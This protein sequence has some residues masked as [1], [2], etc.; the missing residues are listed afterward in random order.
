MD[1]LPFLHMRPMLWVVLAMALSLGTVRAQSFLTVP[2]NL[3]DTGH[4]VIPSIAVGPSGDINVVWLDSGAILFRHSPAGGGAFSSTLT[5]ATTDLPAQGSQPQV[6]VNSA[7]VY[8]AWAGTNSGGG[9]DI[10]FS[11]LASGGSA[12][13]APVNVSNTKG[14]ASGSSAPIPR[15]AVDPSGGV[16]IVWGQSAAY[17]ARTTNSGSSFAVTQ[18]STAPMASESPRTAISTQG[19]VY[20]VWENAGSC[21]TIT[22]GRSTDN[23]ANFTDYAVADQLTVNGAQE[24]GCTSDVQIALGSNN[25]IHLLWANDSPIQDLIATYQTDTGS[26]FAGFSQTNE[27]GFQNLAGTAAHTP[28][29]AID[30]NGNINVVWIGD[31]QQ[32]GGPPVVYFSRSTTGGTKGSFSQSVRLRRLTSTP[33]AGAVATGFPQ[34]A[35][36]PGGAIDVIWQQASATNP[37]NAYDIVLARS[38]DGASFKQFTL[39]NSPTVTANTG[40][41]AVDGNGNAYIAWLGNSGS[42]ADILLNG[43]SQGLTPPPPVFSLSGVTAS[44]SPVSAVINVNGIGNVQ[45][46]GEV[47]EYRGGLLN[48]FV[49]WGAGRSDLRVQSEPAEHIREWHRIRNAER[50]R[51]REAFGSR[52]ERSN[53]PVWLDAEEH[54]H[55]FGADV[56]YQRNDIFCDGDCA[57][58]KCRGATPADFIPLGRPET[59]RGGFRSSAGI[60]SAPRCTGHGTGVL[61]RVNEQRRGQRR[62][63]HG[64][65]GLD[66]FPFDGAGAIEFR[67][68]EPADHLYHRTVGLRHGAVGPTA[69]HQTP[70][71]E[72][73]HVPVPWC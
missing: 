8:V 45:F 6:A 4:A 39:D 9:G 62:G 57:K 50:G 5:V 66:H 40:Q 70:S 63:W 12:F 32:N 73:K 67:D 52:G 16:D 65:R 41:I 24:T 42:S 37:G 64:R 69:A 20:V 43:D 38:T 60:D 35:T 15:I 1:R 13:T 44:I 71:S 19:T 25:T 3:S 10:F 68:R 48:V 47:D 36:E 46:V 22:F 51:F 18:L 56:G 49:R 72:R 27:Q 33:P 11:S 7:G 28:Q 23:G 58:A 59:Q 55:G 54:A 61:R 29:M 17:F 14:I 53:R 2:I 26:N 21:P 30:A 34:I 31:F